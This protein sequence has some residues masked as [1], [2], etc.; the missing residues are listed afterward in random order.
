MIEAKGPIETLKS[1]HGHAFYFGSRADYSPH[2]LFPFPVHDETGIVSGK[3]F[4]GYGFGLADFFA[5]HYVS[6]TP[7]KIKALQGDTGTGLELPDLFA[8]PGIREGYVL[9]LLQ[10]SEILTGERLRTLDPKNMKGLRWNGYQLGVF[11]RLLK[12]GKIPLKQKSEEYVDPVALNAFLAGLSSES[13]IS[14]V[15]GD[16]KYQE[17]IHGPIIEAGRNAFQEYLRITGQTD[18]VSAEFRDAD[19]FSRVS[20]STEGK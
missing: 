1:S 20:P 7:V 13:D 2:L 18:P 9:G 3:F 5:D 8:F 4:R 19:P 16:S 6:P 10:G 11:A 17:D 14:S 15:T 12:E